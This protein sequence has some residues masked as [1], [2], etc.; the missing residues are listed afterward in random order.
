MIPT[1]ERAME[2][3]HALAAQ[4]LGDY[5]AAAR[6]I[7][8]GVLLIGLAEALAVTIAGATETKREYLQT[9]QQVHKF[10]RDAGPDLLLSRDEVA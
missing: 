9:V 4:I 10:L 1:A 7:P 3:G 8:V 6:P 5:V 2:D